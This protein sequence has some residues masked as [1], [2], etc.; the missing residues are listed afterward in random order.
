MIVSRETHFTPKGVR[1]CGG[2]IAI[3][4][5]PLRGWGQHLSAGVMS[6]VRYSA[7]CRI[8]N[9]VPIPLCTILFPLYVLLATIES[10]LVGV[11]QF[12]EWHTG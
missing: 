8:H 10:D 11:P 1:I 7:D 5:Q 9:H 2:P 12:S 3:N 4:M 6:V